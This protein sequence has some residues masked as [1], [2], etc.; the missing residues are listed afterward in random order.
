MLAAQHAM[1]F[2]ATF[3]PTL[4]SA[5]RDPGDAERRHAFARDLEAGLKR[6]LAQQPVPVHSYVTTIVLAKHR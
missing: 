1:F 2:R 4:A 3:M 5:L 6:L